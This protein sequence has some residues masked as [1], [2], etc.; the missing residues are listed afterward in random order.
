MK[1]T[2]KLPVMLTEDEMRERGEAL[3][4]SVETTAA[5]TEE[6]K[7]NDAEINGKIKTSKEITRKLSRII[8]SKTEDREVEC[9]ITKDFERG[10]VTLHRCDTGEVVETRPMTP[11]E[12]QEQMFR[13]KK[14]RA[15]V[16]G[17][18][19]QP[20]GDEETPPA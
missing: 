6:K 1:T 4:E 10:V 19:G 9:E 12:R 14:E 3:A 18:G 8:A 20:F 15:P 16:K 17:K 5:L 11:D 7:A 13:D 2:K